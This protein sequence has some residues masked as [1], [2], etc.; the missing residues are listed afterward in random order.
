MRDLGEIIPKRFPKLWGKS[1]Y[2][3]CFTGHYHTERELPAKSDI[4]ILRL[5]SFCGHDEWHYEKGYSSRRAIN[6]YAIEKDK[7]VTLTVSEPVLS[8]D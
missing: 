2:R 4:T 6:A 1:K 7:G 3:Y 5:P 8:D